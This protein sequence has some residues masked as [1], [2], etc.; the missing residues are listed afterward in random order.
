MSETKPTDA[1]VPFDD[2][3]DLR[4][5]LAERTAAVE[6]AEL[7]ASELT[8]TDEASAQAAAAAAKECADLSKLVE[9]WRKE[10]LEPFAAMTK[11]I[12]EALKPL[13]DRLEAAR[14]DVKKKVGKYQDEVEAAA[15]AEREAAEKASEAERKRAL[16][17]KDTD[18]VLAQA[19]HDDADRREREARASEAVRTVHKTAPGFGTLSGKMVWKWTVTDLEALPREYRIVSPNNPMLNAAAKQQGGPPEIPG[20]E[21]RQ[22]REVRGR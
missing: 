21:W 13:V 15:R 12:N 5:L 10:L 6:A 3:P 14:N 9:G 20:I 16:E 18:P 7:V 2:R 17:V 4:A 22:E 19:L 8:V 1:L 11:R